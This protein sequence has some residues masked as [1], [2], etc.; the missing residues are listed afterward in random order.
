[1]GFKEIAMI[2]VS[3]I[4]GGILA[5]NVAPSISASGMRRKRRS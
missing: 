5:L 3:L 2:V 4:L 1:M